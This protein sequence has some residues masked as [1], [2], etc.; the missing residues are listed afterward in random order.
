MGTAIYLSDSGM[1]KKT[2][3]GN[4]LACFDEAGRLLSRKCQKACGRQ[5]VPNAIVS[6]RQN[7]KTASARTAQTGAGREQDGNARISRAQGDAG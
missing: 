6:K 2:A 5:Q 1:G 3:R 7:V 4:S